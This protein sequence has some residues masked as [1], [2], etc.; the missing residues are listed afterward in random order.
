MSGRCSA[1]AT[2][3]VGTAGKAFEFKN[4]REGFQELLAQIR[5]TM[6]EN[7]LRRVVA[8]SLQAVTGGCRAG[9]RG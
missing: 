1:N 9:S 7:G 8:W 6:Q 5:T 4:N 3:G 2:K